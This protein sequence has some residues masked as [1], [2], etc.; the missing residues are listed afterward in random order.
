MRKWEA[1]SDPPSEVRRVESA[2]LVLSSPRGSLVPLVISDLVNV[3]FATQSCLDDSQ[4]GPRSLM[5]SVARS[6]RPD[7]IVTPRVMDRMDLRYDKAR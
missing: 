3:S 1:G 2:E 5:H 4:G 6:Q 7:K